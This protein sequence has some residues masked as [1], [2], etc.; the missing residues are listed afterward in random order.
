MNLP[1]TVEGALARYPANLSR[2]THR[3]ASLAEAAR[4]CGVPVEQVVQG[5]LLEDHLG[6]LLAVFPCCRAIDFALLRRVTGRELRPAK[7]QRVA[8]IFCD[9][10]AES[11]PPV[12]RHYGIGAILDESLLAQPQ[13]WF[14]PGDPHLLL[15]MAREKFLDLHRRS[16]QAP[17]TRALAQ[18]DLPSAVGSNAKRFDAL[19]PFGN[20]SER[21]R[22]L[23]Q[24]PPPPVM[25]SHLLRIRQRETATHEELNAVIARDPALCAQL[26]RHARSGQFALQGRAS[27]LHEA[28]A[29]VLGFDLALHMALGFAICHHF[30]AAA[31]RQAFWDQALFSA[32]LAEALA[33]QLPA[34]L[35]IT[36]GTAYLVG[37]LHNIGHLVMHERLQPEVNRLTQ[38]AESHAHLPITLVENRLLGIDHPHLGAWLMHAW[39]MPC[40]LIISAREHHNELYCGAYAPYVHLMIAVD[41]LLMAH[42]IGD[43][44]HATIPPGSLTQLDLDPQSAMVLAARIV[45]DGGGLH[46]LARQLCA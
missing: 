9:C 14:E 27:S 41:C 29:K 42:G 25:A 38:L 40:E 6:P 16:Q 35:G 17:F 32:A 44:R 30:Q 5:V 4:E 12:A 37:L 18:A 7:A 8:Q 45:D 10:A 43:S 13:I 33:H 39:Q 3:S 2:R 21:V 23:K 22:T 28:I 34:H 20:L 11:V 24:L 36:P 31:D 46:G 19:R 26:V 15:G 1:T